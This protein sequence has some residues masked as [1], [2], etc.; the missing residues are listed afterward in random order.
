VLPDNAPLRQALAAAASG[1]ASP[2]AAPA[3]L[4]AAQRRV[5]AAA[6]DGTLIVALVPSTHDDASGADDGSPPPLAVSQAADGSLVALLFSGPGPLLSWSG[7]DRTASG[8][9]RAMA[10]LVRDQGVTSAVVDVAGPVAAALEHAE[11]RALASGVADA[12][13]PAPIAAGRQAP[14]RLRAPDPPVPDEA[15]AAL[16]EALAPHEHVLAAYVFEG[17]SDAGGRR[18]LWLGLDLVAGS[19]AGAAPADGVAALEP[20]LPDVSLETT[21]VA[22]DGVLVALAEAA[23]ALYLRS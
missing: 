22:R 9:G 7:T 5:L 20:L 6:L 14:L 8:P 4:S 13:E 1:A 21:V 19:S 10:A 2:A 3:T 18:R 17:P 12:G 15:A 11:L 16:G 23:P